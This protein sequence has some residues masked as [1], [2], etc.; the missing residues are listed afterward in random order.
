MPPAYGIIVPLRNKAPALPATVQSFWQPIGTSLRGPL[1]NPL[2]RAAIAPTFR[3]AVQRS[4]SFLAQ[5]TG[6]FETYRSASP[7]S[8]KV[9]PNATCDLAA[10][11]TALAIH[12][13]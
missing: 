13:R 11:T 8:F 3:C 12:F 5:R 6:L 7:A 9:N 4:Q 2:K 10:E 1:Q